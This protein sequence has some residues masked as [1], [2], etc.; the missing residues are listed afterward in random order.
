M[1]L[2]FT[3]DQFFAVFAS[4]NHAVWPAQCALLLLALIAVVLLLRPGAQSG[5]IVSTILAVLW[6]WIGIV[7]HLAFFSRINPAAYVFG[8]GC[9]AGASNQS[10]TFAMR[11][12][13][14]TVAR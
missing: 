13:R 9:I 2:P 14:T 1:A 5:V 4:Y 11:P 10:G 3:A 6:A 7:Y 8:I 12:A